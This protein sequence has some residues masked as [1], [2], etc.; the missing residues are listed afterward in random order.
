M[1]I[2]HLLSESNERLF[3]AIVDSKFFKINY[4]EAVKYAVNEGIEFHY[5]E[6][7]SW[8]FHASDKL[9]ADGGVLVQEFRTAPR[10]SSPLFH[11][12]VNQVSQ[13]QLDVPVR[14]LMFSHTTK[15]KTMDY[16]SHDY[17][18]F[19]LDDDYHLY[20]SD[21]IE[22]M[23]R[24]YNV[25]VYS[26]RRLANIFAEFNKKLSL[27]LDPADFIN[28]DQEFSF[29]YIETFDEL[30]KFSKRLMSNVEEESRNELAEKFYEFVR[31]DLYTKAKDY[32]SRIV[33]TQNIV[34]QSEEYMIKSE[35][36]AYLEAD[37]GDHGL[38]GFKRFLYKKYS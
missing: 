11:S 3:E 20:Y 27:D 23:T 34:K 35:N 25:S 28:D 9:R 2:K 37:S 36:I 29:N 18:L 1:K 14:N 8:L 26:E 16:G 12:I 7:I 30:K 31:K 24:H 32:V 21:S 10:D 19:P 5:M 15:H 4:E 33:D 13:G 17:V 6:N 38:G 22:D